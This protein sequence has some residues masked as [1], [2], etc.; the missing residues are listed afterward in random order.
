MRRNKSNTLVIIKNNIKRNKS[1][2]LVIMDKEQYKD[3]E[4]YGEK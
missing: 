3:K 2:T 1:N 4:Q